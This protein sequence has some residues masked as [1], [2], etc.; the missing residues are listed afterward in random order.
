M[1]L[2][3]KLS[4]LLMLETFVRHLGEPQLPLLPPLQM[5]HRPLL[6]KVYFL[7]M[8]SRECR[9][10]EQLWLALSRF[11]SGVV[12]AIAM[13]LVRNGGLKSRA[14]GAEKRRHFRS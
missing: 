12:A 1:Q 6:V 8:T 13:W 7:M 10:G 5:Y 11:R 9:G 2:T 3:N 4:K 14:M